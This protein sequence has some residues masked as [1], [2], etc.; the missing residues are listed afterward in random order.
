MFFAPWYANCTMW[1]A[2]HRPGVQDRCLTPPSAAGQ[3]PTNSFSLIHCKLLGADSRSSVHICLVFFSFRD[4]SCLKHFFISSSDRPHAAVLCY[5]CCWF[6][7]MHPWTGIVSYW[8]WFMFL[9]AMLRWFMSKKKLTGKHWRQVIL[10]WL[11]SW[12]IKTYRYDMMMSHTLQRQW[13][14]SREHKGCRAC[15]RE[16]WAVCTWAWEKVEIL[17]ISATLC[18]LVHIQP[19][20]CETHPRCVISWPS[21]R[22]SGRQTSGVVVKVHLKSPR[23]HLEVTACEQKT[24]IIH[25]ISW[26]NQWNVK[27]R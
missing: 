2:A 25:D 26:R 15:I 24:V 13:N 10:T 17:C 21:N 8:A 22:S 14:N 20:D 11:H 3:V 9:W 1:P 7:D 23:G 5:S 6:E 4:S 27:S 12:T 16:D 18:A 19:S